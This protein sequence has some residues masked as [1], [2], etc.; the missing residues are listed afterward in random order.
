VYSRGAVA[1]ALGLLLGALLA[2]AGAD[3]RPNASPGRDGLIAFVSERSIETKSEIYAIGVDG[4]GRVNLTRDK[5][6]DSEPT[7]SPDGT[8]IAFV[9][10]EGLSELYVMAANGSGQRHL[11]RG[12]RPGWSPDSRRIAYT[13]DRQIRVANADGSGETVVASGAQFPSPPAWSPDGSR[14]AFTRLR[15]LNHELV[16][17][18]A[19]GG[20]EVVVASRAVNATLPFAWTN[21]GMEL[22]YA[23][24]DS[25]RAIRPDGSGARTMLTAPGVILRF[26][27][28]PDDRS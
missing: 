27:I 18:R 12:S 25:L 28:G 3:G 20:G 14:I 1:I 15:E 6:P 19:D 26:V 13:G 17:V 7:P 5:R 16:V 4:G 23:V 9:R 2:A 11:G 22:I 10:G 21:D 24:D 8:M